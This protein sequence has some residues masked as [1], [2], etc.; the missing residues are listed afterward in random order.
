MQFIEQTNNHHPPPPPPKTK[1]AAEMSITEITFLD[2]KTYK[3]TQ[4]FQYTNFSLPHP[5]KKGCY[6]GEALRKLAPN[7]NKRKTNK[8][9]LL[10]QY[11]HDPPLISY[12][13][14]RLFKDILVTAG[15]LVYSKI[16]LPNPAEYCL[17]LSKSARQYL[18][19]KISVESWQP[20]YIAG[21]LL[22]TDKGNNDSL[23]IMGF[24]QIC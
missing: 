18:L 21:Y 17:I 10:S 15:L 7:Q 4:M 9:C 24:V 23:T 1:F 20:T 14:G 5:H 6:K 19:C 16:I 2:T 22:C 12:K 11:H 8:S 13:R 3:P